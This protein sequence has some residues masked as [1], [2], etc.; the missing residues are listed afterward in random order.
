MIL[1]IKGKKPKIHPSVF[2]A[3]GAHVVGDVTLAKYSSVWFTAVLRGD[4]GAIRVG[5]RSNVQDGC[6]LHGDHGKPCVLGKGVIMGH[7]ATAHA[8]TIG[9]GVLVGIGARVL[10][11]AKVGAFSLIAA[12]AVVL[13]NAVIPERSLVVGIPG[14]VLRRLTDA[15]ARHQVKQAKRY[16]EYAALYL[17]SLG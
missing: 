1:A 14:K 17:K 16:Q 12:G 9:D 3:P 4:M 8:C 13:E 5:E 7:Q 10:T 2:V 15:E 6:V 11:G